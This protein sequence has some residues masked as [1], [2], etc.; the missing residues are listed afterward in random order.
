MSDNMIINETGRENRAT[1]NFHLDFPA[2]MADGRQF[3]DYRSS[4]YVNLPEQSM[5]TYQY[6]QFLKHNAEKIMNNFETINEH[7][8]GC[9]VCSDYDIVQPHLALTCDGESCNRSI[10]DHA[11]VGIYYVD[12]NK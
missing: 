12:N 7:I 4:C 5:T 9:D 2:R 3:T 1:D 11:G 10:N 6:R 8:S